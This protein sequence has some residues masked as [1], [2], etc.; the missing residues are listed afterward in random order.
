VPVAA[1]V[2]T[3]C[4]SGTVVAL[5]Q[6]LVVPLLPDFP[7]ILGTTTDNASWLVT[8]TLLVGAVATPIVSRLADMIGKRRMMV[9][10]ML[11]MV[12]GSVV[13]ALRPNFVL[14]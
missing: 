7:E 10:C 3:L 14:S 9:V 5:Q 11:V 4:L 8:S 6:T 1:V 2:A 12:A 13:A